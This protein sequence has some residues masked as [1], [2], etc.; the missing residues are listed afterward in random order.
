MKL[1][2]DLTPEEVFILKNMT[3]GSIV[4]GGCVIHLSK[5]LTGYDVAVWSQGTAPQFDINTAIG[6]NL[7]N[8]AALVGVYDT[9]NDADSEVRAKVALAKDF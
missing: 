3:Q 8:L 6:T 1:I 9:E 2:K 7:R 4:W 5:E